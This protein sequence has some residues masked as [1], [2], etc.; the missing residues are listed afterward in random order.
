MV[1]RKVPWTSR[2]GVPIVAD[3]DRILWVVGLAISREAPVTETTREALLL[4]FEPS[5]SIERDR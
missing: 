3:R 5:G 1:D 2:E 4:S